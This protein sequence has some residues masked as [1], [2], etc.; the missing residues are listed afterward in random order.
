[1]NHNPTPM[2]LRM[3]CCLAAAVSVHAAGAAEH[4]VGQKNKS[5][6]VATVEAKV[7]DEVLFR[8]DDTVFHNIFSLTASQSFD[9]GA[10]GP[11]VFKKVKLDKP[12]K[13]EVECA[14]HPRMK[15]VI[16]VVR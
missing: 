15:M 11:G 14:I 6:T 7:G 3:A 1:M 16:D 5:F 9:L 12:G 2:I 13:I 4:V 8:N 10:Y